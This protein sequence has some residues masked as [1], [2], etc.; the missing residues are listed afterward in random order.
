MS[1][2]VL[3]LPEAPRLDRPSAADLAAERLRTWIICGDLAPGTRLPEEQLCDALGVSRN[4]L[5]ESFRLL[6]HERLVVHEL[7]RGVFVR[8]LTAADVTDLY[9][10]RELA[11]LAGVR[12]ARAAGAPL[13][14]RVEDAVAAGTEAA[15]AEDWSAF[16]TADLGFHQ[17]LA[18]LAG[19]ARIDE[20][21]GRL[22]AELRLAFGAVRDRAAFHRPYAGRNAEL[23]DLLRD[24][25]V[26]RLERELRIYL[27]EAR[28]TIVSTLSRDK[29]KLQR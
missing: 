15:R 1:G 28:D 26:E 17:A 21:M 6:G 22:L 11:E 16:A 18:A 25:Q 13:V 8:T 10:V 20:L 9:L 2:S 14:Q 12:A 29:D 23:A 7:N 3:V 27:A 19:S 4:T 24:R 5:R